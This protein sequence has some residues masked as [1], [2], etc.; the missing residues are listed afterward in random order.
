MTMKPFSTGLE[1]E[2]PGAAFLRGLR[3]RYGYDPTQ[4]I[5]GR[6]Q[7]R[8]QTPFQTAFAF[9]NLL[10]PPA[11]ADPNAFLNFTKWNDLTG[12]RNTARNAF[13]QLAGGSAQPDI[14]QQFAQPD[15]TQAAHLRNLAVTGLQSRISPLALGLLNL[16]SGG[17]L[18]DQ[19]LAQS[20]GQGGQDND[21]I[22]F[23]R[24]RLG[25]GIL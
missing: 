19:F 17:D 25:L 5:F 14:R 11:Q 20:G 18:R 8:Q 7:A 4:S 21:F 15:E 23:I 12:A 9:Q 16:P 13:G 10:N 22:N 1:E 6:L 3:D 2:A 24:S